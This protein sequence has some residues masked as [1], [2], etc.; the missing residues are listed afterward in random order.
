MHFKHP[1]LLYALVLLVIPVII[2]LFQLRKFQKEAFTNVAFLKAV[3]LQTRK[4]ST[5]KKWLTLFIRLALLACIILAFAQPYTAKTNAINTPKETVIYLDNSFSMQQQ[6]S[7]GELLKRAINELIT[8]VDVNTPLSLLTNTTVY[9]NTTLSAIKNELLQ[10]PYA[11]EALPYTSVLLKCKSLFSKHNTSK[12]EIIFISDFQAQP[13]PFQ[14]KT[15]SLTTVSVIPL[16]PVNTNNIAIDSVYFASTT[17]MN[18]ELKVVLKNYSNPVENVSVALYNNDKLMAKSAVSISN[19]AETA[20]TIPKNQPLNG[21]LVIEDS[22]LEF[23]NTLYFNI[24]TPSKINVL[25]IT[26]DA[27]DVFLKNIFTADE[28]NYTSSTVKALNYNIISQQNTIVLNELKDIPATLTQ[29]LNNFTQNGG[30]LIVIPSEDIGFNT[31]NNLLSH[32]NTRILNP[33][34]SEKLITSISYGHPIYKDGVFEKQVHNFQ[35]PKVN[36]YYP[37]QNNL[38]NA[39]LSFEDSQPFL[40]QLQA[41][42]FLFTASISKDNSNFKNWALI[43]PTFYK[44]ATSSLIHPQLYF[45]VGKTNNFDVEV[46]LQQ[47][48][49]VNL[50][51]EKEKFIPQQRYFNNKV[52]ITTEQRPEYAGIYEITNKSDTLKRV[53]YNYNRTES[54]LVYDDVTAIKN[55]TV[56]DS[57]S[58]YF[59]ALK[60]NTKVNELWK[61]FLIFALAFLIIEMLVLKYFK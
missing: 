46:T 26:D 28:F 30:K 35:Y 41:N 17:N 31:Y 40:T 33:V 23:D 48:D 53:S 21:S 24:N 42:L 5:I 47:D 8:H 61:W 15:D 52:N 10:I 14:P 4:N 22:G 43:V 18:S 37:L 38:G 6:G 36:T 2:H 32:F 45:T 20:F 25:S 11:N 29:V 34:T 56:N 58:L 9:K 50:G 13:E 60:S 3:A 44:I 16:H 19:E 39:L 59:D 27:S 55:V 57:I 51:N 49:I 54:R 1:E 7:D 12:K